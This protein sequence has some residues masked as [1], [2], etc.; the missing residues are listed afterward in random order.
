MIAKHCKAL[1]VLALLACPMLVQAKEPP[2]PDVISLL[3]SKGLEDRPFALLVEIH[4]KAGM[5]QK[6]AEAA[7]KASQATMKEPGCGIYDFNSDSDKPGTIF[8]FEKW[9]NVAALESHLKQPH[10]IELIKVI[11]QIAADPLSLKVL[12][13]LSAK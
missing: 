13:P 10:T 12:T 5:E 4:V 2:I 6:F 8:V 1:C 11:E 9:K 7:S 3:K